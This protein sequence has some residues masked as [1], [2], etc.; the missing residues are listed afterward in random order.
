MSGERGSAIVELALTLPLVLILA[1]GVVEVA[2]VARSEIQLIH[3]V[4][5]GAR[6]AATSPDTAGAAAAVRRSLG[7]AGSRA[8]VRVSRPDQIGMPATV[9]ASLR[10]R[11][12]GPVFGGFDVDLTA[13][14]SMR[15]ER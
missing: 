9:S 11:V 15:T 7:A 5:E 1:V 10:H 13:R 12:A 3:A 6:Q 2:I 14:A 8:R 4:R